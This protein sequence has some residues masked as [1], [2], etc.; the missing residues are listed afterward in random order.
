M[1]ANLK[2]YG[3]YGRIW[4]L[5]ST[6]SKANAVPLN[7][8]SSQKR[9]L[10]IIF[11]SIHIYA[12]SRTNSWTTILTVTMRIRWHYNVQG[13]RAVS[14]RTIGWW[15]SGPGMWLQ[16]Q[17]GDYIRLKC[18]GDH[19]RTSRPHHICR[20]CVHHCQLPQLVVICGQ[21][22]KVIWTFR[23]QALSHMVHVPSQFQVPCVG[24]HY[25]HP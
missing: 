24:M 1:S 6:A 4:T 14:S 12:G 9:D 22:P 11:I 25:R 10:K 7:H 18:A 15:A 13:H 8:R 19:Q 3:G 21:Q 2:K 20:H 23:V 17:S 5:Q 16:L